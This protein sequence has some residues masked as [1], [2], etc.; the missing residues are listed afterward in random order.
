MTPRARY[1]VRMAAAIVVAAIFVA[2]AF[3]G[4]GFDTPLQQAAEMLG[5]ALLFSIC[6]GTSCALVIPRISPRLWTYRFPVNWIILILAMFVLA[7]FGSTVTIAILVLIGYI[8]AARFTEW[9]L[10]SARYAIITTLTFGIAMSAY[11]LMRA[12][13][14]LALLTA[15]TKERDE[16]EARRLAAEAQLASLESRV[17]PHF[18]FN[19]LNS[20]AALI[21]T[22]PKGAEKMTGQLAS[23]LRSSLDGADRP[24]VPLG[25]EVETVRE[26]LE[27]ERV[28]F[29]D[30]L[31]CRFDVEAAAEPALVPRFSLQT[32]VENAVKYAVSPRRDGGRLEIAARMVDGRVRIDVD[33][34]G[35]GFDTAAIPAHHGLDALRRR[36]ALTFGD[37]ASLEVR[38]SPAGTSVRIDIPRST[39]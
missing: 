7:L 2:V 3:I 4:V 37:R 15:R 12:R 36:L 13:L 31:R 24:L 34:D 19:T 17:Q 26:Y 29:G 20:I 23:L 8:P 35:G 14:E 32:V 39:A 11:E 25:Q 33:D 28:R 10:G 6:I 9:L 18:L 22:D 1:T 30:R 38:S 27:I 21:P 16:A 5:V